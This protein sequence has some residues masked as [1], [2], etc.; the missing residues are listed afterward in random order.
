[1]ASIDDKK[2]FFCSE[3]VA[4]CHK[5]MGVLPKELASAQYWPSTFQ[6]PSEQYNKNRIIP[7]SKAYF[8]DV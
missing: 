7:E 6:E 4:A 3:L 5:V 1:M 8:E 2:T